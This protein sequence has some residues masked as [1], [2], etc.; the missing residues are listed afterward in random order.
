MDAKETCESVLSYIRKSNLNWNI[1]ESPFSVTITLRKSFIKNKD[2][3]LLKS[4]LDPTNLDNQ[5][6][7]VP[8]HT[9]QPSSNTFME[10]KKPFNNTIKQ[11]QYSSIDFAMFNT[12]SMS[13]QPMNSSEYNPKLFHDP[14]KQ[15]K[16]PPK[17]PTMSNTNF[18]R[19]QQFTP[20]RKLTIMSD[21]KDLQ[22]Q[23]SPPRKFTTK[24]DTKAMQ[25]PLSPPRKSTTMLEPNKSMKQQFSS[26]IEFNMY[27]HNSRQQLYHKSPCR[28]PPNPSWAPFPFKYRPASFSDNSDVDYSLD[29]KVT[30][31]DLLKKIQEKYGI[32]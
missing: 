1:V 22:Q 30:F 28:T 17:I 20:P 25:Q 5:T 12:D 7:T 23:L 4:G 13:Q 32:D 21:T 3:S 27:E 9:K 16:F 31:N 2:G 18:F 19:Q 29:D 24:S 6:Q 14:I 8:L 10:E 26:P 15:Q 11:Q